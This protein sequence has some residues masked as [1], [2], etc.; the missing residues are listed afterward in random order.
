M[1]PETSVIFNQLT[2]LTSQED[3]TNLGRCKSAAIVAKRI[4]H[5]HDRGSLGRKSVAK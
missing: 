2:N 4:D 3:Y 5:L 1:V